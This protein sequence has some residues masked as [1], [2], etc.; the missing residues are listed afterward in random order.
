MVWLV[1]RSRLATTVPATESALPSGTP[2]SRKS[3]RRVST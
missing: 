1:R 2:G 3:R